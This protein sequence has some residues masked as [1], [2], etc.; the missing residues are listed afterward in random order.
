MSATTYRT[1][2]HYGATVHI[3]RTTPGNIQMKLIQKSIWDS[4]G[5]FGINANFFGNTLSNIYGIAINGNTP[6]GSWANDYG[7][8]N[9]PYFDVEMKR[10]TLVCYSGGTLTVTD[11]PVHYYTE[12]PN[13]TNIVWAVGGGDLFL[14]D[15]SITDWTKLRDKLAAEPRKWRWDEVLSGSSDRGRSGIGYDLNNN[16]YLFGVSNETGFQGVTMF[17]FRDIAS[18][19]GCHKAI[20]LD[21]GGSAQLSWSDGVELYG[22]GG[23]TRRPVPTIVKLKAL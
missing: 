13:F 11:P 7:S 1:E 10:A 6:V 4:F 19:I 18:R 8:H 15:S 14:R 20:F 17:E 22:H 2:T 9:G 23:I 16:V 5:D 21:G 3:I 12:I